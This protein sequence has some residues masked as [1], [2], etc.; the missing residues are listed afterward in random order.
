MSSFKKGRRPT[1]ICCKC[2]ETLIHCADGYETVALNQEVTLAKKIQLKP[3]ILLESLLDVDRIP[4][5]K[6]RG[7]LKI[8]RR[9]T[10]IVDDASLLHALSSPSVEG[11]DLLA[12][13]PTNEKTFQIA[14][15]TLSVDIV[16]VDLSERVPFSFKR[17]QIGQAIERGLCFEVCYS[18]AIRDSTARRNTLANAMELIKIAKGKRII[19]SSQAEKAFDLRAP[20]DVTNLCN[21]FGVP[22]PLCK[23][24]ISSSC[25]AALLHAATRKK[26][27]KGVVSS[28]C[29]PIQNLKADRGT[30]ETKQLLDVQKAGKNRK[31]HGIYL[32]DTETELP[33][34]KRTSELLD[35]ESRLQKAGKKRKR[36]G[37]Y[38]IDTETE[39]PASKRTSELLDDESRL[40][41]EEE[42]WNLS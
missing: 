6:R 5:C 37:I 33:A 41:K 36:H 42:A 34:S 9:L 2:L 10:V 3:P 7:P 25:R 30:V 19:V 27:A 4:V 40:Q 15:S 39:L 12:V 11:Y 28:T 23:A 24:T 35:A 29:V 1:M 22:S 32:I 17:A 26:T 13:R 18:P 20:A 38:L 21:L 8:L 31:R 14:C 16:S